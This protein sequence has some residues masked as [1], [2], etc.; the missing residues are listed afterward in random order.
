MPATQVSPEVLNHLAPACQGQAGE[1]LG[2]VGREG[3]D[4]DVRVGAV[5][6]PGVAQV[7][8]PGRR[9]GQPVLLEQVSPV[10][11]A[12]RA[13]V[14][15]DGV[16]GVPLAHLG[17]GPR[18]EVRLHSVGAVLG[19][20]GQAAHVLE[21][22]QRGVLDLAEV[23]GVPG[24]QGAV[25][26]G[27]APGITRGDLV[28]VHVDV[29]MALVPEADRLRNAGHPRPESQGDLPA[30]GGSRGAAAPGQRQRA[31]HDAGREQELAPGPGPQA[32]EAG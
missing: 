20:V 32:G 26:L 15:R 25:H 10:E 4:V 12:H 19:Q 13:G 11:Q 8:R 29:G 16:D 14:L 23:G 18:D 9:H 6:L 28:Q 3:G 5:H 2:V 24:L 27:V 7:L 17:P 30:A 22:R 1:P 31:R 21:V